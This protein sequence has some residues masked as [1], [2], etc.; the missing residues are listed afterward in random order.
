MGNFRSG[1]V[2]A[3][4]VREELDL[5]GAA[6]LRHFHGV[7]EVAVGLGL[8]SPHEG[9]ATW[10]ICLRGKSLMNIIFRLFCIENIHVHDT[11]SIYIY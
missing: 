2:V 10:G 8:G 9:D 11:K 3:A 7:D 5:V 6:A 4:V 1:E